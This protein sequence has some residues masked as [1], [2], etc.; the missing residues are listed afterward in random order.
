MTS[1]IGSFSGLS[2]GIQW[3]DMIDQIMQ[4]E[5]QRR[6]DPLTTAK[7]TE[8]KRYDAW[9]TWQTLVSK[10][11]DATKALRDA[12]AFSQFQV[13]GGTSDSSGRTLLTATAN[14]SA[15]PG[16]FGVEVL[17]L[18][19]ANKLSGSV[20][21]SAST[22][23]GITGE[24]TV[25]GKKVTVAVTD[26]LANVRDKINALNSGTTP[27]GVT[28]SVLSTGTSQH[29]LVLTATSTGSS[30]IELVD[31]PTGTLQTLGLVDSTRTLNLDATGGAQSYKV[32]SSTAAIAAML[33]VTMPPPSTITVGGRTITVD[34]TVDS[35]ATITAKIMAAGGNAS[36]GSETVEGVTK[37]RLQTNDTVTASTSDGQR[38]LDILGF[39]KA[40]RSGIA[41]VLQSDNT[42]TDAGNAT[43]TTATRLTD[44]SVNGNPLGIAVGDTF[45][46][47][48]ARGDCSVVNLSFTVGATD[49]LQTLVTKLNANS[50]YGGGSRSATASIVNGQ[51]VVTDG[52]AGDSQLS[53]SM[54]VAQASG[55]TV[56]LGRVNASTVGRLREVVT[57]TD[58]RLSVDGVVMRRATNTVSDAI[59][60]VTL[61]LQQSEV[62]TVSSLTIARDQDAIVKSMTDLT[63]AY[64]DMLKFRTEQSKTDAPLFN[65]ST[66]RANMST[67]TSSILS[68][69]V[70]SPSPFT[71]AAF[72]GLSL[73][74]DGTLT[75]DS[76]KFKQALATNPSGLTS[77]FATTGTATNGAVSYFLSTD[78][79]VPG[80]YAIDITAAATTPVVTG[81]GF[82]GT[83]AD[84]AAADTMAVTDSGTGATATVQLA[85]GDTID[86]I[87]S[88]LNAEFAA[89]KMNITAS[90]NGNDLVMTSGQY[91]TAAKI[92]TAFTAGG[93]DGSAQLGIAAGAVS[94]TDV[95]GTIGGLVATGSGQILTGVAGGAT[96]GLSIR[97]NGTAT[98]NQGDVTFVLGVSGMLFNAAD[99]I[100][101]AGGTVATQQDA[102]T[103][104]I[105]SLQSRADTV[106]Q[107]LERRRESLTAQFVEME[108]ALSIIQQQATALSGFISQ[109]SSNSNS[110]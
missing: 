29:R 74:K 63:T 104:R 15:S 81:A 84:D 10:F 33:G 32:S 99:V 28:A 109:L 22:A 88:K 40:G 77:L 91:G 7:T 2:S 64:N 62:G 68:T 106:T 17:D 14:A 47:Q 72:G 18:A 27:S 82:S 23:L 30:G 19:R 13:T 89:N 100:S 86:T 41:Q 93:T 61:N 43:A 51:L 11:R 90:K 58:A 107:A 46:V 53:L 85:N 4:L 59:A 9:T 55:G 34:L 35:L 101:R 70:G 36:V 102:L 48:G 108:R 5:Q 49:T 8:Q 44:L 69:V 67:F 25:N 60:G 31:D 103:S 56:A 38:V 6:L 83:Y 16:T 80:T 42:F 37:Y 57:G 52:T 73:Q 87:I 96:E 39:M 110:N 65:N 98:G 75:L 1:P 54:S 24:F 45:T 71:S 20:Q 78:K 50:G 21:A 92:T 3:R 97:Y 105:N 79:S 26:T 95:A 66:L 12:T 76:D 94:G